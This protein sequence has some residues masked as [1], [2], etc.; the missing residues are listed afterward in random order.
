MPRPPG[1][2]PRLALASY[3]AVLAAA[4]GSLAWHLQATTGAPRAG[5]S[6]LLVPVFVALLAAAEYLYVRFRFGGDV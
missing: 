3:I 1:A 5:V 6:W 2:P 4:S